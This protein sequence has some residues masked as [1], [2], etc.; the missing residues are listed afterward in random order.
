MNEHRID[1]L[2]KITE[3][4][5]ANSF[6]FSGNNLIPQVFIKFKRS[7]NSSD[8]SFER[9]ELRTLTYSLNYSEQNLTTIFS[10]ENELNNALTL[11]ESNW[12]DSF[13]VGLIDCFLKNW[14][15]KY[16]K[17]LEQ[18]EHFISQKLD[19]Y[20]GNRSALASF[21]N[22]KRFFNTKNGDLILGDTI[23]KLNKPIQE[24]TKI[25]GVP[26]SWFDYPYFSK[27]IV[28]YYERNKNKISEEIDNL[29]EVLLKHNNS[30]T[31]KRLISKIIIQ[32]TELTFLI[33]KDKAKK[34]ALSHLKDPQNI[35][36]SL[37]QSI[38]DISD[39]ENIAL[40]KAKN[41]L[42]QWMA[43]EFIDFFFKECINDSRRRIF[44]MKYSKR[45]TQFKIVGS[46]AIKQM[47]LA[48]Q[49]I[50]KLVE[51]RFA[52]TNSQRDR[53]SALMFIINEYLFVEFSDQGA[54]YAYK[55]SNKF[56]P[57]IESKY[58][59][60]I[61]DLKIPSMNWLVYRS[62]Y[63]IQQTN[64]EGK[65]GHNDGDLSWEEVATYWLNNIA[66]I[67]V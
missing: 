52:S 54:F 60:Q 41:I 43:E 36:E 20:T 31:N 44:W 10:N 3:E 23:A 37:W 40:I 15:T 61:S 45:I 62:G 26:E 56:A 12:R 2:Q 5:G 1:K 16:Q 34:I 50:N 17:S 38:G 55:L 48:N 46:S 63:Y 29:N 35:S 7:I 25:L 59:F 30:T 39:T 58:F 64:Q 24:A 9:R 65:L 32:A 27:V 49:Q 67:N 14:E 66:G 22:N 47:L 28:T 18:L 6:S 19:S 53:N 42:L 8:T 57:S 11:L 33:I 51:P 21:K 4:V 13:L